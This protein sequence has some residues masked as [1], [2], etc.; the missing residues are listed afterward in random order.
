MSRARK[1]HMRISFQTLQAED[2][3][4]SRA[5]VIAT[6]IQRTRSRSRSRSRTGQNRTRQ[7]SGCANRQTFFLNLH[8]RVNKAEVIL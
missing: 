5:V 1:A 6:T 4:Q 3:G 8:S 7:T 2:R